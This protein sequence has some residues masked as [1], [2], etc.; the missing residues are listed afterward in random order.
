MEENQK[1]TCSSITVS[2]HHICVIKSLMDHIT[3]Y[4]TRCL[5]FYSTAKSPRQRHESD[6]N[7]NFDQGE[8]WEQRL[9]DLLL[10]QT[11]VFGLFTQREHNVQ[12]HAAAEHMEQHVCVVHVVSL[13][14]VQQVL[15][16]A[17]HQQT[18]KISHI[19]IRSNVHTHCGSPASSVLQKVQR[20]YTQ[21]ERTW[22]SLCVIV[23]VLRG[24]PV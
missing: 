19:N 3:P 11:P 21:S 23:Q 9:T 14:R 22:I 20:H 24:D 15:G 8:M 12:G 10:S 18:Q 5:P 4:I 6:M 16:N 2:P 1:H 13:P 17:P 7:E